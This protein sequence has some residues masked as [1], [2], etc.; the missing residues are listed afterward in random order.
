MNEI[1]SLV[2]A[3]REMGNNSKLVQA[4]GGNIS[5]K[6][7]NDSMFI[8][9]SGFS[10][11]DVSENKGYVKIKYSNVKQY[12]ESLEV[13][14]FSTELEEEYNNVIL[15]STDE[16]KYR[17]SLETG[18]HTLLGKAVIHIH[19]AAVN[20]IACSTNG[21]NILK[22]IFPN[23]N[24]LWAPYATPGIVLS[25]RISDVLKKN[26][27]DVSA[28]LGLFLENHGLVVSSDSM[29]KC[30]ENTKLI[31]EKIESYMSSKGVNLYDYETFDLDEIS[32]KKIK[33]RLVQV[34]LQKPENKKLLEKHLFPDSLVFCG[35][36]F[37]FN[38]PNKDKISLYDDGTIEL[39]ENSQ[40]SLASMTDTLINVIYVLLLIIQFDTPKFIDESGENNLKKMQSEK[41]RQKI[42][43]EK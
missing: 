5:I 9:A 26:N 19:P 18:F 32:N 24:F 14:S 25:K 1:N 23:E 20:A 33:S 37:S 34:F 15:Q 13:I 3:C 8:K 2:Q 4:S 35:C 16:L 10:L 29:N 43:E 28:D 7:S 36:G 41:Y 31:V 30:I 21:K 11:K 12:L 38:E 39:P 22:E 42:N 17:P 40:I 27:T 6:S